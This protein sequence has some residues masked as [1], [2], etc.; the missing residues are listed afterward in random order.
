MTA[1]GNDIVIGGRFGDTVAAGDGG[2]IVIGD[3]GRITAANADT[4]QWTGLPLT[5]GLIETTAFGDGGSDD[6]TAGADNDIVLGGHNDGVDGSTVEFIRAGAGNNIVLGD[7]GLIDYV[8]EERDGVVPGADTNASDIDLIES[9]FTTAAGGIDNITTLG[10]NDIV[11]GGRYGDTVDAGDGGDI[12]IG[13]SGRITAASAGMPQF[14]G[15]P[16]TFG[17]IETIEFGDG[18]SDNI[19]SGAGDDVVLGGHNDGSTVEFINAG[20]GN[21]IV[22]GDDG[23]IDYVVADGDAS[24]IDLIESLSTTAAGGTDNDHDTGG[25]DIVIGG[26]FGRTPI[27]AG[28]GSKPRDR[29]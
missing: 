5:V 12:V 14:S 23:Q 9:L 19:T 11:I 25:N 16:M 2:N 20:A 27:D 28:D 29:R 6:I 22:L 21:N 15:V 17:L 26:R 13:D 3:S 4:P 18:G 1:G 10:G 8:R 24:D 7:D